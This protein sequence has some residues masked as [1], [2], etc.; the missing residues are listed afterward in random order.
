M[1]HWIRLGPPWEVS[2][3]DDGRSRHRR[4]FGRPR[5]LDAE[6]RVWLVADSR[7]MKFEV[8]VNGEFVGAGEPGPFAA[9]I[10]NLLNLRN[11]VVFVIP[12]DASLGEIALEIR[13]KG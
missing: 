13:A 1:T 9:D 7:S 4:R 5:T 8:T 6:E 12:S 10:T 11:E 2:P 3:T